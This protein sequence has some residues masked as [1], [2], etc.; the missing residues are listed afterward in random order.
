LVKPKHIRLD[1][2]QFLVRRL[3]VV[4]VVVIICSIFQSF[5][6]EWT[7]SNL[8]LLSGSLDIT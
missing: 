6:L 4:I 2:G 3:D 7:N 5:D 1:F 8:K